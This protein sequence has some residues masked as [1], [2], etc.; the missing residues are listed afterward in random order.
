MIVRLILKKIHNPH[1]EPFIIFE[2]M[3]LQHFENTWVNISKINSFNIPN[4]Q[5]VPSSYLLRNKMDPYECVLI[6][7]V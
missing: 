2:K 6:I 4:I 3:T 1:F 7:L 5:P